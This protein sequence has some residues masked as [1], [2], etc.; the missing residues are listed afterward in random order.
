M[1]DRQ[2]ARLEAFSDG[3]FGFAVTLLVLDVRL[4]DF[5]EGFT[6]QAA[7]HALRDNGPRFLALFLTFSTVFVIWVSHHAV[8]RRVR[9]IDARLIYANGLML[10][11]IAV[12]PF[13]TAL[14]AEGINQPGGK[15]AASVYALYF[16]ASSLVFGLILQSVQRL[17]QHEPHGYSDLEA[18]KTWR[19]LL[20][21]SA[22]LV[23]AAAAAWWSP[24]A[25]VAISAL[26]WVRFAILGIQRHNFNQQHTAADA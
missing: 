13:P 6:V 10:L 9:H 7:A 24:Y 1:E 12:S 16:L 25:A 23:V 4:P 18:H 8:M 20:A 19:R 17:H 15:L 11:M 26:V 21:V 3:V 22:A 2:A 5:G 14:L